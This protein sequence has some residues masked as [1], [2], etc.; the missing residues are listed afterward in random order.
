MNQQAMNFNGSLMTKE[1]SMMQKKPATSG[2]FITNNMN[3][4]YM[5]GSGLIM[6]PEGFGGKYYQDTLELVPG[7]IPVFIKNISTDALAYVVREQPKNLYSCYVELDLSGLR[8]TAWSYGQA[9]WRQIKLQDGLD[10]TE[11]LLL[12]PAPLPLNLVKNFIVFAERTKAES[13]KETLKAYGNAQLGTLKTASK[14]AEF[15]KKKTLP[16]PLEIPADSAL[17]PLSVPL[18]TVNAIGGAVNALAILSQSNSLA[19]TACQMLAGRK[20]LDEELGHKRFLQ[21]INEWACVPSDTVATK[22]VFALLVQYLYERIGNTDYANALDIILAHFVEISETVFPDKPGAKESAQDF[23]QLIKNNAQMPKDKVEN[24]L[25]K[26][27]KPLQ[28][29]FLS[30]VFYNDLKELFEKAHAPLQPERMAE[31]VLLMGLRTGWLGLDFTYK[32]QQG[33]HVFVPYLMAVLAHRFAKTDMELPEIKV[34]LL[35]SEYFSSEK[36]SSR[37][38]ATA[39]YLAKKQQWNCVSTR[40]CLGKGDYQLSIGTGGVDIVLDGEVKAVHTEVDMKKFHIEFSKLH[41][42]EPS[43]E[44]ELRKLLGEKW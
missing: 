42:L 7:W 24:L 36:W 40:I 23:I 1:Q 4:A 38:Q 16:W 18:S 32:Q 25:Q 34:P 21:A 10:G 12:L 13:F 27:D 31:L 35:L 11:E 43:L 44:I 17:Q 15:E 37:Q 9:Q 26:Y 39:V 19:R 2:R 22:D 33:C 14:K 8:C 5:L 3:M 28:Q 6:P 41:L 20:S 29:T 30:F